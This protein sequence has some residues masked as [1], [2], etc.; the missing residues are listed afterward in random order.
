MFF[1]PSALIAPVAFIEWVHGTPWIH[2]SGYQTPGTAVWDEEHRRYAYI[3]KPDG[4][5]ERFYETDYLEEQA[6]IAADEAGGLTDRER[7][8]FI[9]RYVEQHTGANT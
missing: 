2:F 5:Q 1:N 9:E 3:V 6:G 7:E 8:D 4:M